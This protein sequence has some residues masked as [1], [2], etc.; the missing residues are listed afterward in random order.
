MRLGVRSVLL[1]AALGAC[2]W[3]GADAQADAPVVRRSQRG[4]V[5]QRVGRTEISVDYSRP[6]ARGR[7]LFGGVVPWGKVWNPGADTATTVAFSSD[8]LVNGEPLRAGKYSL[9]AIPE[10]DVWTIIFSTAQP[11]WHLPYPQGK[12]ALRVTAAPAAGSHMEVM[13]FY[14]PVVEPDSAVLHLHWGRPSSR[15]PSA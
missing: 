11:V 15:C 10:R 1:V 12:D 14:F 6:V 7:T 5:T 4:T 13:A 3:S 8:V 2:A 9:W